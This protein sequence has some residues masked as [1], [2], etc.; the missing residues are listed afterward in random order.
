M[1]SANFAPFGLASRQRKRC[2][3][4]HRHPMQSPKL[5]RVKMRLVAIAPIRPNAGV[6]LALAGT[7][8]G[9]SVGHVNTSPLAGCGPASVPWQ[10]SLQRALPTGQSLQIPT[11]SPTVADRFAPAAARSGTPA[12]RVRRAQRG[13]S[14]VHAWS[15]LAP[16]SARYPVS[17]VQPLV[18]AAPKPLTPQRRGRNAAHTPGSLSGTWGQK[19]V[20][21]GSC[22]ILARSDPF[23]LPRAGWFG[24]SSN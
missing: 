1:Q 16:T 6:A 23:F 11:I 14:V 4:P 13:A 12:G 5:P 17:A 19:N 15:H 8:A 2:A 10:Q 9:C 21:S 20:Q 7:G 18:Q 22:R 3:L 24:P